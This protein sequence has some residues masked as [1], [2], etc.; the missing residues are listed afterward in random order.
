MKI[1]IFNNKFFKWVINFIL[2]KEPKQEEEKKN[3]N[4]KRK[5]ISK[6][7]HFKKKPKIYE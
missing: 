6:L 5:Y 4:S 1:L 2:A 3:P 7:K